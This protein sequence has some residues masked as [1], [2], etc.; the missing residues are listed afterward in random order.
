MKKI[1]TFLE[2]KVMVFQVH[3]IGCVW[4]TP[5]CNSSHIFVHVL[6]NVMNIDI[7]I[8]YTI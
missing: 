5:F 3:S 2:H 7:I 8:I 6:I 1:C 4:K